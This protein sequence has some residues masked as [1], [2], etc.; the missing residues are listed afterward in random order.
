MSRAAKSAQPFKSKE[1]AKNFHRLMVRTRVLEERLIKMVRTGDGFFW[2]GGPGEE[3]FST[4][5]G[6]LV[7]KVYGP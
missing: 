5:L 6:L 2:I 1:F 4:A 3:A 7:D